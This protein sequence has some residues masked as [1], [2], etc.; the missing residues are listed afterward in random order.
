MA[1]GLLPWFLLNSR[2]TRGDDG[3]TPP[4][5]L[6]LHLPPAFFSSLIC[7]TMDLL[8][9]ENIDIS[10]CYTAPRLNYVFF[11]VGLIVG[12]GGPMGFVVVG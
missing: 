11:F 12:P 2:V 10:S 6:H 5:F 9:I 1:R 7:G 4:F 8:G 3:N